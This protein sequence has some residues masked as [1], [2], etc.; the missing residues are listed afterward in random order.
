[1]STNGKG[2]T[3][4]P[5]MRYR[6]APAAVEWLCKAFGFKK[7]LVVPGQGN[8]IAHAE[9]TFGNGM[10]MIGSVA[11]DQFGNLLKQPE[12][13]GGAGTQ[14]STVI[15]ADVDAHYA[16]AKAAGAK[17][18]MELEKKDYGGSGYSCRDV[19]G[20]MWYFGSYNPWEDGVVGAA[21]AAKGGHV[22]HG[23][24][25]VRPYVYGYCD[26]VDFVKKVFRA[27]EL[28]RVEFEHGGAHVECKIGDGVIVLEV[29][30]KPIPTAK[31][32][33]VYVYVDDVDAAYARALKVGA[34]GAAAPEDKP[35]E[36]RSAGVSDR[37]GNTWWMATYQQKREIRAG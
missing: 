20:H 13:I 15:V 8:T 21:S 29:S 2:A 24:A 36:E 1:M 28:E 11:K 27:E 34:T 30:D 35:Y 26:L 17:I 25:A 32:S 5:A 33:S 10:V 23:F 16:R 7:K 31:A 9:L 18:V 22:R 12:E 19:E 14:T 4:I 37:F 6:D 3:I